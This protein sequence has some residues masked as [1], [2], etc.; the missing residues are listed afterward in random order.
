MSPPAT[1]SLP[2]FDPSARMRQRSVARWALTKAWYIRFRFDFRRLASRLT[3]RGSFTIEAL[4]IHRGST[5]LN[6]RSA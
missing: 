2:E 6:E 1:S 4:A 5:L 3:L